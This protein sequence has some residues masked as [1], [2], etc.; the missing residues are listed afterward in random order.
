MLKKHE[1]VVQGNSAGNHLNIWK[2]TCWFQ[3]DF[4]LDY[5]ISPPLEEMIVL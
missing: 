1:F 3:G 4:R 5:S 2:E